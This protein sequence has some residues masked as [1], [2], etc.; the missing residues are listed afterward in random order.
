MGCFLNMLTGKVPLKFKNSAILKLVIGPDGVNLTLED[1]GGWGEAQEADKAAAEAAKEAAAAAKIEFVEGWE[2]A[3][4]YRDAGFN[5]ELY[6]EAQ[7][8]WEKWRESERKAWEA[9]E[10]ANESAA[11]FAK[12]EADSEKYYSHPLHSLYSHNW[13]PP[14]KIDKPPGGNVYIFYLVRH[15]MAEHNPRWSRMRVIHR[16]RETNL[17]TEGT[18]QA[19]RAGE[20]LATYTDIRKAD[21]ITYFVSDLIRTR[22]TM[23]EI[24]YQIDMERERRGRET[25]ERRDRDERE[26]RERREREETV[27]MN[28]DNSARLKELQ[29]EA[30]RQG[31]GESR[32]ETMIVLPC[33]HEIN[34]KT[35]PCEYMGW[36]QRLK[37]RFQPEN[38]SECA[39]NIFDVDGEEDMGDGV[40]VNPKWMEQRER[41]RIRKSC[42]W[43]HVKDKNYKVD[44][45]LYKKYKGR[46]LCSDNFIN[47]AIEYLSGPRGSEGGGRSTRKRKKKQRSKRRSKQRRSKRRSKRKKKQRSR[48]KKK[49]RKK[50]TIRKKSR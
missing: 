41:E 19:K 28:N 10:K 2:K 37:S 35:Y 6:A 14:Q 33:S 23:G 49:P 7:K 29:S 5:S 32:R 50:K 39:K 9:G 43:I 25:R 30:Y 15:G 48:R 22:Q 17:I 20:K 1:S 34:T 44:W 18:N 38:I 47:I 13:T 26:T 42:I 3:E 36:M 8:A 11:F 4:A 31:G 16:Y 24:M 46:E 40:Y 12:E 45:E 21:T 27:A